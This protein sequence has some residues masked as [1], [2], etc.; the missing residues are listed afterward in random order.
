MLAHKCLCP[1]E[2]QY[3]CSPNDKTHDIHGRELCCPYDNQAMAAFYQKAYCATWEATPG[4]R[5]AMR[6]RRMGT[7]EEIAQKAA[8][9][10]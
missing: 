8:D 5:A 6:K 10:R 2:A 7:L 3:R 1:P 4:M 9:N